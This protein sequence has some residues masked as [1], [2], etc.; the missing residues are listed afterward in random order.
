LEDQ[1]TLTV[2]G[3]EMR[4]PKGTL[5]WEAC[6]QHG[7]GIPIFCYH[8]KL[9]P[10]GACRTCLVEQEGVTKGPIT[11][12]STPV[13]EG[14]KIRTRSPIVEKA[15]RGIFEFLLLNHPL[16][17]PIC[18]RGGE[19]PLQDQTFAYGPGSSRYVEPK[20]H[21]VK[22]VALGPTIALD[23]ERCVLC[24][25]CV[26]FTADVAEDKSIV[27]QDRGEH[28]IVG[29]FQD[30]PYVSNFSGNVIELCPVGALTSRRQR[31][32][33]RPW[34]LQNRPSICPHCAFG[35]NI[36]VSV[37]KND[38]VIRFLSR[39][40]PDVDD[41]WLCDRGRFNFEFIS[42][43]E[44]LKS[45]LIKREGAYCEVSWNEALEFIAGRVKEITEE[46]GTD[47]VAGIASARLTNEDLWTFKQFMKNSIGSQSLDHYPR[48]QMALT[49]DG[50]HAIETLD[51]TLM[52][53]SRLK[54]VKT[55]VLLGAD[56]SAREPV[57]ELRIRQAVNKHGV[58]L[59]VMSTG[60][61]SLTSKAYATLTYPQ[62][63]FEQYV[64]A[65][66]AALS[67]SGSPENDNEVETF[68]HAVFTDGPLALVYDDTFAGIQDKAAALLAVADL[69]EALKDSGIGTIPLLDEAN[70]MGARDLGILP[71]SSAGTQWGS[72][73]TLELGRRESPVR[74]AFILGADVA[75][76]LTDD[77]LRR[78]ENLDL[79]VVTELM[80]TDTARL[81][82]VILPAAS[83][84][85]KSGTFTNTE[86]R[87]Q[88]LTEVVPSP[89]I[90]RA[91]WEI[92]V[93][94]SQYFDRPLEFNR[95]E[96][97]WD[98]LRQGVPGYSEIAYMDMGLSG[99]R[100][101][102]RALQHV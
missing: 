74:A 19:C 55:I 21:Q 9:G 3:Q 89:G 85:E 67:V 57:M 99:A 64:R 81:A 4:V 52:P 62:S 98:D 70:S 25:R 44:R 100:P 29:T 50:Q 65:I 46:H 23:R 59:A 12:C 30:Q 91:D 76:N 10:I 95:P 88:R 83:F 13:A 51:F 5:L 6:K 48:P 92:L 34:E 93:D 80:L 27:L 7:I 56:P 37:R 84:A 77:A 72:P 73:L 79:L 47:A 101:E 39:D 102:K 87:I 36:N 32:H 71:S 97:I 11:A 31:F 17:C 86:R 61:V 75:E 33:F 94:L 96:D 38:E 60:E 14:M 15:Q 18:D 2:D 20:R 54:D 68:A 45:P 8:T 16:D 53:I 41:S 26:R 78:L 1:V 24:W 22:P 43:H 49:S 58:R 42:S 82:D 63:G 90:A 66:T 28:T 35:C 69:V 40:N